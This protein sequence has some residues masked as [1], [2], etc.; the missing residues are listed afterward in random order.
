M[1]RREQYLEA[2]GIDLWRARET[3]PELAPAPL[4]AATAEL[5]VEAQWQALQAEV[6]TCTR[7][8]LSRGRTQ[9]V[10]GVGNP[11]AEL[12]VIGEAPGAEEDRQGEPFVGRAGQLLNSMLRAIGQPRETVYIA[13]ILKCRPPGNRDPKPE[14]SASCRPFLRRQLELLRPRLILAVGRIATQNLLETDTPI[15]RLRGQVHRFGE[16]ATPLIATYHPAYL[17]RSPG[18]KRKAWV[19]LKFARQQLARLR[20]QPRTASG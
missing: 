7:C 18:E 3:A 2:L 5:S 20:A 15:A 13:N 12:L 19:D 1:S 4:P 11:R 10:F 8:E 9:T 6:R 17:L 14:E 16:D